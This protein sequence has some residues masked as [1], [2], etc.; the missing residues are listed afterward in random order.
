M[1]FTLSVPTYV[2][3]E[4]KNSLWCESEAQK[5]SHWPSSPSESLLQD[6]PCTCL[7]SCLLFLPQH[8]L[9][10]NPLFMLP[11]QGWDTE[12]YSNSM[13]PLLEE[14]ASREGSQ[15]RVSR[16]PSRFPTLACPT[17]S[18]ALLRNYK[19]P[20]AFHC[21]TVPR[22]QHTHIFGGASDQR[23]QPLSE[24]NS[25]SDEVGNKKRKYS[26]LYETF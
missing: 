6:H 7:T 22:Q 24:E 10:L 20:W 1:K 3:K 21:N 15:Q 25:R 12:C 13:L 18:Q 16:A 5:Q 23:I 8:A 4:D 19:G 2:S 9:T 11:N 17:L 14:K 26:D